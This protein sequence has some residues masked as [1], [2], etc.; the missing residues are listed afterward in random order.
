MLSFK[1]NK[2]FKGT[3]LL[4]L[5]GSV[6]LICLVW[7]PSLGGK[8]VDSDPHQTIRLIQHIQQ[9]DGNTTEIE[10]KENLPKPENLPNIADIP[11]F[12]S[13]EYAPSIPSLKLVVCTRM[14]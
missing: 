4:L 14:R 5:V 10:K 8:N 1:A 11:I 3:L 12:P 9:D 2:W 13:I 6:Q 7:R